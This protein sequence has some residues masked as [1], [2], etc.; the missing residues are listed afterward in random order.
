VTMRR[1]AEKTLKNIS[2]C[3]NPPVA[4]RR[5][6]L[7]ANGRVRYS[8]DFPGLP[9]DHGVALKYTASRGF[10]CE[11]GRY[12]G[13]EVSTR[14]TTGVTS[15]AVIRPDRAGPGRASGETA[16]HLGQE[17][18]LQAPT[19][20]LSAHAGVFEVRHT[21]DAPVGLHEEGGGLSHYWR[22]WRRGGFYLEDGWGTRGPGGAHAARG[23]SPT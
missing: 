9:P 6:G 3:P 20:D 13:H 2:S 10:A 17:G 16:T 11:R 14:A 22:Q 19:H 23:S 4:S 5:G 15:E 18:L 12:G 8:P 7:R 1:S 21:G